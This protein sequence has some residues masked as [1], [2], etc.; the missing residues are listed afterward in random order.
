MHTNQLFFYYSQWHYQTYKYG[1]KHCKIFKIERYANQTNNLTRTV[2]K[3]S[4]VFQLFFR[5]LTIKKFI[6]VRAVYTKILHWLNHSS[7][8]NA[9][10]EWKAV[11]AMARHITNVEDFHNLGQRL[12]PFNIFTR[13]TVW[14]AIMNSTYTSDVLFSFKI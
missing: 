2:C 10:K 7:T 6:A 1:T 4:V 11:S 9:F 14:I 12:A 3:R 13:P 8:Q 5:N